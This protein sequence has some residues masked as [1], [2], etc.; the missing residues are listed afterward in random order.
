[1][2]QGYLGQI[3]LLSCETRSQTLRKQPLTTVHLNANFREFMGQIVF[4]KVYMH[5]NIYFFCIHVYIY[6]Y[7]NNSPQYLESRF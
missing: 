5:V 4:K 1:M 3:F 2:N 6:E 7:I